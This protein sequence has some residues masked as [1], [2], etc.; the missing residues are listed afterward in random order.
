MKKVTKEPTNTNRVRVIIGK[1]TRT[2]IS[3]PT[4]TLLLEDTNVDE[5]FEII[6]EALENAQE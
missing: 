5:V 3:A 6:D 2:S 4:K 1:A